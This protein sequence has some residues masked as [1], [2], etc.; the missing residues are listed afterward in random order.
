MAN[1]ITG[2][3]PISDL[4]P[5]GFLLS[6]LR[7]ILYGVAIILPSQDAYG[8]LEEIQVDDSMLN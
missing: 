2:C 4:F 1:L 7:L 6:P 5:E 3:N 8:Y